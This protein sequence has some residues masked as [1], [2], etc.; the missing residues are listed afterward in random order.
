MP[1]RP[2]SLSL[3]LRAG[4]AQAGAAACLGDVVLVIAPGGGA[5]AGGAGAGGVPDLGPVPE[6]GPGIVAAGFVA[7]VAGVGG[8][9]VD[10]DHQVG[11]VAGG[12]QPPA[13]VPIS[14][15]M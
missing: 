5:A 10:R 8:D 4:V 9:R 14:P 11:P 13:A 15:G 7:V 3:A 6:P 2:V 12:A 1:E